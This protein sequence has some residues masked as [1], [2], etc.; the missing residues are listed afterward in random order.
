MSAVKKTSS[1]GLKQFT[2]IEKTNENMAESGLDPMG[3]TQEYQDHRFSCLSVVAN[4]LLKGYIENRT[5]AV[6]Q[7]YRIGDVY[8]E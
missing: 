2:I 5:A 1:H 6:R 7:E 3:K 8:E 4:A